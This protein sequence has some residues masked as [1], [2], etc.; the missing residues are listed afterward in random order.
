MTDPLATYLA[1][2]HSGAKIAIELLDAMRD[3]H[4]DPQFR[5]FADS[6][7]PE[8]KADD[9]TLHSIAEKSALGLARLNKPAPGF[10]KRP[11]A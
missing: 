4:D 8:I 5:K 2:H 11:H 7:L 6:L 9:Q 10:L 1:D 3:Q